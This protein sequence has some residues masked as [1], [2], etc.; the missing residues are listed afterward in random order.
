MIEGFRTSSQFSDLKLKLNRVDMVEV[1][2]NA[3]KPF[4]A[5]ESNNKFIFENSSSIWVLGDAQ[6]LEMVMGNIFGNVIKYSP[7]GG[8]AKVDIVASNDFATISIKDSGIGIPEKYLGK[9]FE[10]FYRVNNMK[11]KDPGGMGLGLY[12]CRDIVRKHG[13]T[14]WA[15]NNEDKGSTFYIKIPLYRGDID[16]ADTDN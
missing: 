12:I 5:M 11:G 10:S 9:I 2:I 3:L 4:H 6:R 1:I 13:G 16:A 14:I 15:E 7:D 8:E